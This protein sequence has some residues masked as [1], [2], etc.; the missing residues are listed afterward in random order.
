MTSPAAGGNSVA[1]PADSVGG[2]PLYEGTLTG[3]SNVSPVPS[4]LGAVGTPPQLRSQTLRGSEPTRRSAFRTGTSAPS[5]LGASTARHEINNSAGLRSHVGSPD[6]VDYMDLGG[7]GLRSSETLTASQSQG[8]VNKTSERV[9]GHAKST[10]TV[11]LE[12][13]IRV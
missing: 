8:S 6:F 2:G 10:N 13:P 3:A 1:R 11:K 5:S 12:N 9:A 4:S 7:R